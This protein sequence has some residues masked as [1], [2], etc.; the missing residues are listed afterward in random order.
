MTASMRVKQMLKNHDLRHTAC[1]EEI[2]HLFLENS[3]ALT[4]GDIETRLDASHDRVTI[5]RTLKTFLEKNI[6]HKVLDDSGNLKYAMEKHTHHNKH[7]HIHFKCSLCG[8]TNCLEDTQIPAIH[9]PEGYQL[10][11]ANLLVQGVCKICNHS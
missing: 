9:L 8:E 10:S 7:T 3:Y 5:Y 2:L 6:I 11:Q 1:R 4:H